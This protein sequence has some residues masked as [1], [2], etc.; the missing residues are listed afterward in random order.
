MN[1]TTPVTDNL[2]DPAARGPALADGV[3]VNNLY[4]FEIATVIN[5]SQTADEANGNF[6]ADAQMPGI[7]GTSGA[8]DG[9]DAEVITFVELPVGAVRWV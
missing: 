2:A 5:L 3:K 9:I 7:P 4:K 8:N 1:G 6:P